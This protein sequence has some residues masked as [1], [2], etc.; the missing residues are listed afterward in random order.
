MNEASQ[1]CT[2]EHGNPVNPMVGREVQQ[3]PDAFGGANRRGGEKPRGRHMFYAWRR[4]TEA[5]F[6]LWEDALKVS[7]TEGWTRHD[8]GARSV[9]TSTERHEMRSR[10]RKARDAAG[11]RELRFNGARLQGLAPTSPIRMGVR[12][13][14]PG[15]AN[16]LESC[17]RSGL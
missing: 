6:G 1:A 10:L 7:T 8:L 17:G 3:T 5:D 14:S 16:Y 13:R 2:P 12:R 11:T 9:A 15:K 4:G